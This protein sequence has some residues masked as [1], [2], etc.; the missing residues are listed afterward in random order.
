MVAFLRNV[1][2]SPLRQIIEALQFLNW[3]KEL[4]SSRHE[5]CHPGPGDIVG[6]C[7]DRFLKEYVKGGFLEQLLAGRKVTCGV[8]VQGC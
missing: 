5:N 1:N 8:L 3:G 4:P 2:L 6:L 7:E